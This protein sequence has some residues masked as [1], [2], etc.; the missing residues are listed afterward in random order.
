M[1][2]RENDKSF[3]TATLRGILG[4]GLSVAA[5]LIKGSAHLTVQVD[6]TFPIP[7]SMVL[8]SPNAILGFLAGYI[9]DRC[10]ANE[11][12]KEHSSQPTFTEFKRKFKDN[13]LKAL[14][15]TPN[16]EKPTVMEQFKEA[17]NFAVKWEDD[18]YTPWA[19]NLPD[20][21]DEKDHFKDMPSEKD[22]LVML[23]DRPSCKTQPTK[24]ENWLIC[25]SREQERFPC[26]YFCP[27]TRKTLE[28]N[29]P[30]TE[31]SPTNAKYYTKEQSEMNILRT[32]S[33]VAKVNGLEH[34]DELFKKLKEAKQKIENALQMSNPEKNYVDL[35][36]KIVMT[37]YGIPNDLSCVK[38][39]NGKEPI[40]PL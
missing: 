27:S 17:I 38:T 15:Q 6:A 8:E 36:S 11:K 14:G 34:I 9:Y 29:K 16:S 20:S 18:K 5:I 21:P 39:N 12:V 24:P 31:C 30:L 35:I 26:V 13:A 25:P 37:V 10:S 4:F 3:N 7:K 1:G 23:P 22:A 40:R 32:R 19:C 28:Q 33:G 2:T